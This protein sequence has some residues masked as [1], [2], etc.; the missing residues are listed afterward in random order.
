MPDIMS[1]EK[2]SNLMSRIKG[3][4]TTP[5]RYIACLLTAGGLQFEQHC[6]DLAGTPD[7]VLRQASTAVFVDGDFWHG[8]RFPIW[9]H[10]LSEPWRQRIEKNRLRD[11][12]NRRKLRRRGWKVIRLWEHQVEADAVDCVARIVDRAGVL[13]LNWK[14][15]RDA[16]AIL[17]QLKRRNRLP[18]P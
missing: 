12:S 18:K 6:R 9:K 13:R 17:P 10:R 5:E 16:Y 8:W 7:F 14:A 3:K 2:R 15:V 11:T 1:V 4:N